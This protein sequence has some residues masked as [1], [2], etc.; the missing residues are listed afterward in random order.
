MLQDAPQMATTAR[1]TGQVIVE[2]KILADTVANIE[3]LTEQ[4]TS[5]LAPVLRT[6]NPS[7][8]LAGIDDQA[9]AC[10]LSVDL[11]GYRV[12]LVSTAHTLE[13]LLGRLDI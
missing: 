8:A 13:D 5:Q 10:S 12:R 9:D 1:Q 7:P 6:P 2:T 3:R 11:K 4:L